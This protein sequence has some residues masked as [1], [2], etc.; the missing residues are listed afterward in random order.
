MAGNR[1]TNTHCCVVNMIYKKKKKETVTFASWI[2][3]IVV[4]AKYGVEN[5]VQNTALHLKK[6][7]FHVPYIT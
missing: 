2:C 7:D 1:H 5:L 3:E 6:P 4:E